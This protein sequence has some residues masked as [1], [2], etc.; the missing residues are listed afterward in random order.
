MCSHL[1][2]FRLNVHLL[3]LSYDERLCL[4]SGVTIEVKCVYEYFKL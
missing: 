2:Q 4:R 3:N 1:F